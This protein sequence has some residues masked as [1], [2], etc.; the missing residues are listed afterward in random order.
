M[1][2]MELSTKSIWR[3]IIITICLFL[4]CVLLFFGGGGGGGGG[5]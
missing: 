2:I 3:T 4:V 5:A 1:N